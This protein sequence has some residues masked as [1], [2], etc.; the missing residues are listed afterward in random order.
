MLE[1]EHLR[2]GGSERFDLQFSEAGMGGGRW[3]GAAIAIAGADEGLLRHLRKRADGFLE[4]I[5]T[6]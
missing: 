3:K 2:E 1:D 5:K 6:T 4:I